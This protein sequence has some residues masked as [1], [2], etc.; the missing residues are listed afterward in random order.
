MRLT[1]WLLGLFALAV[2]TALLLSYNA[3]YALLVFPPWRVELSLNLLA[4]LVIATIALGYLLLRFV[5]VLLRLPGAV[6]EYHERRRRD[7]ARQ[8]LVDAMQ[9]FLEGRFGRAERAAAKS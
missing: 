6:R 8:T 4:L 7:Q 3:G 9:A 1:L 5:A 2:G